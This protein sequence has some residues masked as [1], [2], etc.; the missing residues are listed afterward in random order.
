MSAP[1]PIRG[2]VHAVHARL[3]ARWAVFGGW[4]MPLSY[5]GTVT[6][7]HAVRG[8]VGLFD[9]SHLGKAT[10]SGPGAADFVN[11]AFTNDVHR[12]GPG[13]AQYTLCCTESGGVIDDI[14][15]YYVSDSEI[16]LI[17]N[18]A[19][20]AAVVSR[21][22]AE[23]PAGIEVREQHREFA[24][25]AV[26]GPQ[27]ARVLASLGLP[28]DMPY[29]SFV[30][31]EWEGLPIRV[32]RTGYTGEHGYELLPLWD[33]AAAVFEAL[34]AEVETAG[35]QVAG[36]GARDTLRLEMGYPLHGN[37]LTPEISPV[38]GRSGWA[39]GWDKPDFWG[40]EAL[41]AQRK[42]G[43]ERV[44]LGVRALEKGVFRAGQTISWRG[45][46][47]GTT[48]SGSFSPTLEVGIALGLLTAPPPDPGTEVTVDVR[49]RPVRAAVVR[50]PFVEAHTR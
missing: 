34:V 1:D 41:R 30:D 12:I 43:P 37:E 6:E 25:F 47:I 4:Q 39:V 20:T 35:G 24:V 10:V 40:A 26:Q 36:L 27:S 8:S 11:S 46:P 48:T 31:S 22:R 5:S 38:E 3:H 42:R 49:G 28:V 21:L 29:L 14:F 17:P 19:N 13:R 16:F 33:D 45:Q 9:V 44:L 15:L 23:A 50:P 32:C 18:A 7:H 2:P